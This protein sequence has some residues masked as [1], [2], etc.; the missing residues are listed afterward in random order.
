MNEVEVEV[1]GA[2]LAQRFVKSRLDIFGSMEVVPEL[3]GEPD[4]VAG[5]STVL[6]SLA[7]FFL[8]LSWAVSARRLPEQHR[9]VHGMPKHR[10]YAC[11]QHSARFSPP[12]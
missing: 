8:V 12:C 5:D 11:I 1:F 4:L 3:G 10:R 6:D 7:N 2:E 9:N